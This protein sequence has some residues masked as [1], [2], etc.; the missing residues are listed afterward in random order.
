M[1]DDK[2]DECHTANEYSQYQYDHTEAGALF[3]E[4]DAFVFSQL[5]EPQK[6]HIIFDTIEAFLFV[7]GASGHREA[8]E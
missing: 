8:K 4:F 5:Q 2:K 6:S 3:V 7:I 1:S